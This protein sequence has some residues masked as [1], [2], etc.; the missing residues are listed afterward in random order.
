M[1]HVVYFCMVTILYLVRIKAI[2]QVNQVLDSDNT[3]YDRATDPGPADP[4]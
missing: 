1:E 4:S 3:G 2:L